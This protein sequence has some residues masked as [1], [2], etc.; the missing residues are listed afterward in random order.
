MQKQSAPPVHVRVEVYRALPRGSGWEHWA[1]YCLQVEGS[2]EA[3]EAGG[4]WIATVVKSRETKKH[5]GVRGMRWRLGKP[6]HPPAEGP[7]LAEA[8]DVRALPQYGKVAVLWQNRE[9]SIVSSFALPAS[10]TRTAAGCEHALWLSVGSLEEGGV[11]QLR[12]EKMERARER[13]IVAGV[14]FVYRPVR[15][16]LTLREV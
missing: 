10:E 15:G 13:D 16:A 5:A 14:W 11:L 2:G 9:E 1:S 7:A 8:G 12:L 3:V 6:S 4:A